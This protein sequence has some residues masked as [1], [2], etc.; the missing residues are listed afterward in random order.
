MQW[1]KNWVKEKVFV[2]WFRSSL[3]GKS[4]LREPRTQIISDSGHDTWSCTWW[5]PETSVSNTESWS[6]GCAVFKKWPENADDHWQQLLQEH[7]AT[8]GPPPCGWRACH[9]LKNS[10][11][12]PKDGQWQWIFPPAVLKG[13]SIVIWDQSS[14][15]GWR[16]N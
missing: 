16:R 10:T 2:D 13:R 1:I 9:W 8:Q 7:L 15:R 3:S 5:V 4:S 14:N 11:L 6:E 12:R